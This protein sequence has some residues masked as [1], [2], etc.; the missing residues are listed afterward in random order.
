MDK[1][2][3]THPLPG[4]PLVRLHS[5]PADRPVEEV[6][7]SIFFEPRMKAGVVGWQTASVADW[8]RRWNLPLATLV[9]RLRDPKGCWPVWALRLP[10]SAQ[11]AYTVARDGY[12]GMTFAEL[13]ERL[14]IQQQSL[15]A[16]LLKGWSVEQAV[17]VGALSTGRPKVVADDAAGVRIP[18]NAFEFRGVV[19][20]L[21]GH[22]DRLGYN[23]YTVLA[24]TQD[25]KLKVRQ[26]DGTVKEF[27][28]PAMS[29][30]QALAA[31]KRKSG[32]ARRTR[33]DKGK[34]RPHLR[35]PFGPYREQEKELERHGEALGAGGKDDFD[36]LD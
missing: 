34:E 31:G 23:Y 17:S 26:R 8:A 33:S 4:N 27:F 20:T 1:T 32:P 19:D 7:M 3:G 36:A 25:R 28:Y 30:A 11:A 14:G 5:R 21:R 22:C 2:E 18:A 9:A 10:E 16:R 12:D 35:V 15:R 29:K 24:R 6:N 13:A